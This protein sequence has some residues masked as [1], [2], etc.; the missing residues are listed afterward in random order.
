MNTENECSFTIK[1]KLILITG[2]ARGNGAALA[3]G[4]A[5]AGGKII[6]VDVNEDLVEETAETIRQSG[7]KA[8]SFSVDVS[9][10]ESC[11]N[12]AEEVQ[13]NIGNL[14]V[15]INNAGILK[16]IPFTSEDAHEALHITLSVNLIGP[17][18]M[19]KAF[20]P[21]L[22]QSKG[23]V[24]NI[25][26]IQSF[27]AA[28]TAF[29]YAVSKG[30]LAQLTRMLAAELAEHGIR[31][32]AIAPGVVKTEMTADTRENQNSLQSYL[33][34]IPM[35]RVA[36]PSELIGPVTFLASPAASYITG[37]ILPVDGGYLVS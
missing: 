26:S 23:N 31:V 22:K 17:F 33:T 25:A 7:G 16:R 18:N 19:C 1:D 13:S 15:L 5:K 14:D 34:H 2:A 28:P 32:N 27:V 10:I 3:Q 9:D 21:A 8:W 12:L 35:R 30:G 36:L 6:L 20:L 24:I 29:S 11:E 37:V 4:M